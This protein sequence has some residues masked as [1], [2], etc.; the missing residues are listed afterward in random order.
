MC[1]YR[2]SEH[3]CSNAPI[4]AYKVMRKVSPNRVNSVYYPSMPYLAGE[5]IKACYSADTALMDIAFCLDKEIVHA[6]QTL[7]RAEDQISRIC[8]FSDTLC[9]YMLTIVQCEIPP[10]VEYW[11]GSDGEVGARELR[12]VYFNN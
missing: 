5:T 7:K 6:Y 3:K 10:G 1:F 11:L 9:H 8:H 12:I 4:T 2:I